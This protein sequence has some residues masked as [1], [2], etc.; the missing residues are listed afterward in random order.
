M[1][2]KTGVLGSTTATAVGTA[3]IYQCPASK[4]AKGS[5][6]YRGTLANTGTFQLKVNG[7]VV[8]A[9]VA[10][11]GAEFFFSSTAALYENTGA[12]APDGIAAATTVGI[13]PEAYHLSAGDLVELVV[14][15]VTLTASDFQFVGTEIDV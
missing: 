8:A 7:I 2:D 11:S 15:V 1:T 12:T 6:F 9:P 5:F 13:A 10:A 14:G 4:A 3:T